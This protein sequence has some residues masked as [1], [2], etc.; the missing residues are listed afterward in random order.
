MKVR[1]WDELKKFK[2]DR[3]WCSSIGSLL[4]GPPGCDL[5]H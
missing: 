2:K 1:V 5:N 3:G 4:Q